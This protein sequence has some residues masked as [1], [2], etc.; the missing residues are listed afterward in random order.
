MNLLPRLLP[1]SIKTLPRKLKVGITTI[2][3]NP[4]KSNLTP[5][6]KVGDSGTAG[7]V[8]GIIEQVGGLIDTTSGSAITLTSSGTGY[9]NGTYH[10]DLFPIT[11]NGSRSLNVK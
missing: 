5:S 8:N 10:V 6:V 4:I 1:N 7:A 9:K 2:T 11:G 3:S